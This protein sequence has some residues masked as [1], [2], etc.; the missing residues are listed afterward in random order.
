[1]LLAVLVAAPLAGALLQVG[2]FQIEPVD[3]HTDLRVSTWL[4]SVL[5]LL[6]DSAAL[7]CGVGAISLLVGAPLGVL[8]ARFDVPGRRWALLL[9]GFPL[10]LPP[11]LLGLGWFHLLGRNGIAGSQGTSSLLFSRVGLVGV[12][13]LALAPVVTWLVALAAAG[14]D[15]ALED[16]ARV[17]SRPRRVATHVL[18]PLAAPAA[19]L[20]GLVVFAL[21][22]SE[23]GVPMLLRIRTYPAVVFSRLGGIDY[24]PT[25]AAALAIPLL[26]LALALA[27]AERWL[28]RHLSAPSLAWDSERVLLPLGRWR[29]LATV[30][31]WSSVGVSVLPLL[32]LAARGLPAASQ[33]GEWVGSSVG[34]ALAASALSAAGIAA[35]GL[36]LGW[37]I[38]R[39]RPAAGLIDAVAFLGFVTP[40]ALLGVGLVAVW[41]HPA[42]QCV[43]ASLAII[44]FAYVARY[45]ALGVRAVAAGVLQTSRTTEDAAAVFG[46][47]FS[48]R[49][50]WIVLPEQRRALALAF[51][52]GFVFCLRDL[53][54]AALIYPAGSEPLAVRIFTLEANAPEGV[55]CALALLQVGVTAAALG[56]AAA[57][58]AWPPLRSRRR[59]VIQT[60]Q[61]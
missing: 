3:R 21:A 50:L 5:A 6:G 49:L 12:L 36:V 42:T 1:M 26:G 22:F 31:V 45:A 33:V 29:S 11:F 17:A 52:L 10:F 7:A 8:L 48:R 27:A 53:E 25:Q 41:N 18:L 51:V 37:A 4:A 15:P 46:A 59:E 30:V 38:G 16:A 43:Y 61:A 56:L 24:A 55:V 14:V 57:V 39:R 20:G 13:A 35:L 54:T 2:S 23:L 40:A 28:S 32:A 58:L 47:G 34:N 44:V 19:A 60:L 9:H